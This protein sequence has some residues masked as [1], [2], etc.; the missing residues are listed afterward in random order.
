MRLASFP[1]FGKLNIMKINAPGWTIVLAGN[2][3][4]YILSPQWSAKNI[5]DLEELKVEF[6]L[7]L[8]MPP[9]FSSPDVTMIPSNNAVIFLPLQHDDECLQKAE[10]IAHNLIEKL[11]YT[12]MSAF[13]VNFSFIEDSPEAGLLSIFNFS[14]KTK[15]DEFGCEVK[16]TSITRKIQLEGKIINLTV[17]NVEAGIIVEFNFHYEVR[18]A[19]HAMEQLQGQVVL[20]KNLAYKMLSEIYNI[21]V[22][23]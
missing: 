14:D 2:W 19:S 7:N 18:D 4:R 16:E 5:F 11:P 17:N 13:G 8:S 1:F 21:N 15:L 9:R 6:A 10:Q 20:N 23:E 12:P 22:Q 3:N